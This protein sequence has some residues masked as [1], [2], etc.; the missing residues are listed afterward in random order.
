MDRFVVGID[1]SDASAAALRAAVDLARRVGAEIHAVWAWHVYYGST[2]LVV[3]PLVQRD[4]LEANSTESLHEIVEGC[5]TTDVIVH[6]HVI[7]GE[8]AS[9]LLDAAKD[10]DMLVVGSRG[11]GTF[12]GMLLGSVSH[13]CVAHAPCPVLVVPHHDVA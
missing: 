4:S 6:E 2:E 9:V 12:V 7:E 8:P 1:G 3:A 5:D 13:K 10:A 11:H